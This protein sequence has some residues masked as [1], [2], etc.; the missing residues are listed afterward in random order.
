M[1]QRSRATVVQMA[2][3]VQCVL[4]PTPHNLKVDDARAAVSVS[5]G[6]NTH[7]DKLFVVSEQVPVADRDGATTAL[8]RPT[9]PTGTGN[10]SAS[11]P[12]RA[13]LPLGPTSLLMC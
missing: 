8:V 1:E 3:T 13:H 9:A 2:Q 10:D 6:T 5:K 4:K 11:Q 12:E 7:G